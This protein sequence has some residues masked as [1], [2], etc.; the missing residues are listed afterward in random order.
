MPACGLNKIGN[1]YTAAVGKHAA[2]AEGT[3]FGDRQACPCGRKNIGSAAATGRALNTLR[4]VKILTG[5]PAHSLAPL[6]SA[7]LD[8]YCRIKSI[9]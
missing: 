3:C 7:D 4:L 5:F 1:I 8:P 2:S 9:Q 6:L